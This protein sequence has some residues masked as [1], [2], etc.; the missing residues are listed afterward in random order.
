MFEAP[1]LGKL[2]FYA[3]ILGTVISFHL[4][5]FWYAVPCKHI[6]EDSCD[7]LRHFCFFLGVLPLLNVCNSQRVTKRFCPFSSSKSVSI[8]CHGCY[9]N[10]VAV[11]GIIFISLWAAQIVQF[12]TKYWISQFSRIFHT[13]PFAL[14]QHFV[15]R[16]SWILYSTS[17]GV[18]NGTTILLP[19]K[20]ILHSMVKSLLLHQHSLNGQFSSFLLWHLSLQQMFILLHTESL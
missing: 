5:L 11:N 18:W 2:Q 8:I 15:I 12:N 14:A 7:V 10:D 9:E 19:I 6:F 13:G 20:S 16:S 4:D 17:I 1:V 3:C